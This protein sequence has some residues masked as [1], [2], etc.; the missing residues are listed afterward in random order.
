MPTAGV[1]DVCLNNGLNFDNVVLTSGMGV[2]LLIGT[3]VLETNLIIVEM[4]CYWGGMEHKFVQRLT[5]SPGVAEVLLGSDLDGL[6]KDFDEVFYIEQHGLKEATGLLSMRIET[7]GDP[8]Y[9]RQYRAVLTKRQVIEASIDEMLW[10]GVIE[11]SSSPWASPVAA[12]AQERW[13]VAAF[14]LPT[15]A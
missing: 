6:M 1:V 5:K 7:V 2:P 3:D 11:P 14:A 15:V 9:Q 8:V 4:S 13:G 10:D 12:C